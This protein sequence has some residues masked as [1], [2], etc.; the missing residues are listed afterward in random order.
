MQCRIEIYGP[1]F[2]SLQLFLFPLSYA[3]VFIIRILVQCISLSSS[4]FHIFRHH[5]SMLS[6]PNL[7]EKPLCS[8]C[9]H[10]KLFR[11]AI[12]YTASYIW[13]WSK[14]WMRNKMSIWIAGCAFDTYQNIIFEAI[15]LFMSS[16]H[17]TFRLICGL[18]SKTCVCLSPDSL[19]IIQLQIHSTPCKVFTKTINADKLGWSVSDKVRLYMTFSHSCGFVC[20]V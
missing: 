4:L 12:Q 1:C 17:S 5:I 3:W 15:E 9:V 7:N 14:L 18:K 20:V 2:F 13:E 19:Y 6:N 10:E 16:M 8:F 11:N